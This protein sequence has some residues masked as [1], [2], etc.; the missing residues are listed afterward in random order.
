MVWSLKGHHQGRTR[1]PK[2]EITAQ[3]LCQA[4]QLKISGTL[5]VIERWVVPPPAVLEQP[6]I[7]GKCRTCIPDSDT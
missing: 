5:C 7:V 3:Y 2:P 6:H 1:R 4:G